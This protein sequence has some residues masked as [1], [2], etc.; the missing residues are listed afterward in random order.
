MTT[1]SKYRTFLVETRTKKQLLESQLAASQNELLNLKE[2][3]ANL[4]SAQNVITTVGVL[5]QTEFKGV[6]EALVTEA[7]HYVF[8]DNYSFEIESTVSRSQ[9]EAQMW[10]VIDDYQHSLKDEL[11]GGVVDVCSFVLRVTFW[12]LQVNRT[13]P[14]LIFDE[15]LKN[16]DSGR[17]EAIGVMIKSLSERLG[18]QFILVTHEQELASI[19]DVSYRVIITNGTSTVEKIR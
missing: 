1:L 5:A 4:V 3:L 13:E 19:A 2:K 16:V 6:V 8:G 12:A 15:P 9:A 7:L 10:V 14:V 11:G 17:L 18:V